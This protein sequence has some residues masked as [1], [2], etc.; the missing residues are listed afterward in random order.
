[1]ALSE[2]V[3]DTGLGFTDDPHKMDEREL[4]DLILVEAVSCSSSFS[5]ASS[6]SATRCV[7]PLN[8]GTASA[9]VRVWIRIFSPFGVATWVNIS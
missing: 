8:S 5:A 3:R 6:M 4:H 7:S 9:M 1:M 2:V